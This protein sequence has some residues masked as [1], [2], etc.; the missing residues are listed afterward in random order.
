MIVPL[1]PWLGPARDSRIK[2]FAYQIAQQQIVVRTQDGYILCDKCGGNTYRP[3]EH[4]HILSK[5]PP[6]AIPVEVAVVDGNNECWEVTMR[7]QV[8]RLVT[9]SRNATNTFAEYVQTLDAWEVDILRHTQVYADP[10]L[11]SL[12]LTFHFVAGSDGWKNMGQTE[13]LDGW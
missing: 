9:H 13:L 7:T 2:A 12:E 4:A 5:F 10:M 8:R 6:N 1:G 11:I 3:S